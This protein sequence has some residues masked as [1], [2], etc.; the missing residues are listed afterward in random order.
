MN[1]YIKLT[2][3]ENN[4]SMSAPEVLKKNYQIKLG[5]NVARIS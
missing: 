2:D 3:Q 4:I 1:Q 5:E